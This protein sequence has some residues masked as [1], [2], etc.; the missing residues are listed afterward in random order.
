MNPGEIGNKGDVDMGSMNSKIK[1]AGFSLDTEIS[2]ITG[3]KYQTW[4]GYYKGFDIEVYPV[5]N[6]YGDVVTGFE[7]ELVN[8][9]TGEEYNSYSESYIGGNHPS[10][11]TAKEWAITTIDEWED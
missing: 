7:Y 5:G 1:E 10:S 6:R 2:S 3:R 9:D 4:R 8:R 11:K